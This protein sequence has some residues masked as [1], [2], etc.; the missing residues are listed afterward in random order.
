[1]G[2]RQWMRVGASWGA[3]LRPGLGQH[4]VISDHDPDGGDSRL[5]KVAGACVLRRALA[6]RS[7]CECRAI[8]LGCC[9]PG[10]S[11][12]LIFHLCEFVAAPND[13]IGCGL[14][15]RSQPKT[16]SLSALR[17]PAVPG[18]VWAGKTPL[19]CRLEP[20]SC[21]TDLSQ[22]RGSHMSAEG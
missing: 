16:Q 9:G 15:C 18:P 20:G 22:S 11:S 4:E 14:F 5:Q 1:M 17:G 3:G 7:S 6:R 10:P 13:Q 8:V 21:Q 12:V 2:G 19:H